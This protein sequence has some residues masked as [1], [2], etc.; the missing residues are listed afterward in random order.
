MVS[1]P[2][3][4][5]NVFVA[6]VSSTAPEAFL[7]TAYTVCDPFQMSMAALSAHAP[8]VAPNEQGR[9]VAVTQH[10][11]RWLRRQI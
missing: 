5:V 9:T 10:W 3:A 4:I 8:S 2:T 6:V 11:V 7:S 1:E